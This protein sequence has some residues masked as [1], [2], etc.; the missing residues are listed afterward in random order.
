MHAIMPNEQAI[1][2]ISKNY[3]LHKGVPFSLQLHL[4]KPIPY[5][6]SKGGIHQRN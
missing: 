1:H 6:T 3:S 5:P 4:I 2:Y